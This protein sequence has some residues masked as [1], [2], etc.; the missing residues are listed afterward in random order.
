MARI[1]V[2]LGALALGVA[3]HAELRKTRRSS[4]EEEE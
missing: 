3:E 1:A 4:P 2:D